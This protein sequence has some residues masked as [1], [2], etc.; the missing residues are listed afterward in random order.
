M[1][2]VRGTCEVCKG[3]W[4]RPATRTEKVDGVLYIRTGYVPCVHCDGGVVLKYV[5]DVPDKLI[6]DVIND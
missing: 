5:P 2:F 6:E 3:D 4:L 1:P